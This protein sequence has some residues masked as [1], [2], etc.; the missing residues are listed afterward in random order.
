[1]G[2]IKELKKIQS[3]V[4]MQFALMHSTPTMKKLNVRLTAV[5]YLLIVL[6]F[7]L[8]LPRH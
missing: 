4:A 1:L 5:P 3:K 8:F 6:I 2:L 7:V